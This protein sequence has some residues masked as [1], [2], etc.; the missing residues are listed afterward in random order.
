MKYLPHI[1]VVVPTYNRERLLRE[2]LDSI[3][4]QQLPRPVGVEVVVVDDGSTDGTRAVM[5]RLVAEHPD[6]LIYLHQERQGPA[7]A[8]NLGLHHARGRFLAFLDSDDLWLPDKLATELDLFQRHPEAE[9]VISDSELWQEGQLSHASR[10]RR[11]G[12]EL[13][14]EEPVWARDLPPRWTEHSLFSTCCMTLRR[15]VLDSLGP[16]LFDTSLPSHEDWELELRIYHRCRALVLPRVT[17]R[18]RRFDDGTRGPRGLPKQGRSRH[19]KIHYLEGLR[20]ILRRARSLPQISADTE[21][22]IERGI[23]ET[24]ADLERLAA[25][26]PQSSR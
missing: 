16:E 21:A 15:S 7:A 19:Q 22:A 1:S 5:E 8:R 17:A 18:A 3:A 20:R 9:V 12:L 13:T 26:T 6:E 11:V 25:L 14:P 2:A 23:A 10:F 24:G 4:A